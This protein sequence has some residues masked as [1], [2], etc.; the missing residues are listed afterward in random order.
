MVCR[1]AFIRE[2]MT[3]EKPVLVF[4]LDSRRGKLESGE[5]TRRIEGPVEIIF[6][7]TGVF[8]CGKQFLGDLRGGRNTMHRRSTGYGLRNA[9][10]SCFARDGGGCGR[11][12]LWNRRSGVGFQGASNSR[13]RVGF[14]ACRL[15]H[16]LRRTRP[17]CALSYCWKY[18][19]SSLF[20]EL[21]Q[22]VFG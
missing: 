14:L 3:A 5:I 6:P 21:C 17:I 8:Q 19:V 15:G 20:V 13:S 22:T 18:N 4:G 16:G 12:E 10:F 1:R 11:L 7:G 9:I 2:R